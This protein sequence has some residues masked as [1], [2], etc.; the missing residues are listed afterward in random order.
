MVDPLTLLPYLG[1][2]IGLREQ[3]AEKTASYRDHIDAVEII[4]ENYFP[5]EKQKDLGRF[6][7]LFPVI[8]HGVELSLGSAE[9]INTNYLGNI[10]NICTLLHASYYSDHFALTRL[11][12]TGLGHLS[13]IWFTKDSLRM[14]TEK[15]NRMQDFLGI[16]LVLE[17]ITSFFDIPSSDFAE[18][19]FI[20]EV[21][22]RTHCGLLL[23]VANVHINAHNRTCDPYA[24]LKQFPLERVVQIH[25]AGG[26]IRNDW[27]HDTHSQE[28]NGVNEGIWP[29]FSWVLPRTPNLKAV[30][31]E[32]DENFKNDFEEMILKDVRR[33]RELVKKLHPH[34]LREGPTS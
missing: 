23:D 21:G 7:N 10:K 6:S 17:N 27:Y 11:G 31:I 20:A 8:P 13:P 28:L 16:P 25:L 33:A 29:L 12:E 1:V 15:V 19:E 4:T 18:E 5:P 9:E 34:L 24:F 22:R 14:V 30:I 3:I 26:I 32:R 2:G